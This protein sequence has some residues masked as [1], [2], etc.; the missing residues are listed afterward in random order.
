MEGS[1]AATFERRAVPFRVRA[2]S[3]GE[4]NSRRLAG[5]AVTRERNSYWEVFVPGA[6]KNSLD[7]KGDDKPLVMGWMHKEPIGRWAEFEEEKDNGLHVAGDV[8]ET[9]LGNDALTLVNDGAVTGLSIG[10]FSLAEEYVPDG[11][12]V[13]FDTAFGKVTLQND[14]PTFYVVEADVV[15]ASVVMTPA[16]DSARLIRGAELFRELPGLLPDAN[17]EAR[18]RSR[19]RLEVGGAASLGLSSVRHRAIEMALAEPPAPAPA[20]GPSALQREIEAFERAVP[21]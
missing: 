19:E 9:T 4:E 5:Y 21:K 16:D 7:E 6:F 11:S 2:E 15:E 14:K 8:S 1:V 3:D 12:T 17:Q 20:P 10:F 18:E 13:T